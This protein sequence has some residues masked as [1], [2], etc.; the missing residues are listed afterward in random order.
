M[1]T[2]V[3]DPELRINPT[4]QKTI[5]PGH[6]SRSAAQPAFSHKRGRMPLRLSWRFNLIATAA[7]SALVAISLLLQA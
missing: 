6:V 5:S 4:G 1:Q 3:S 2:T 7:I